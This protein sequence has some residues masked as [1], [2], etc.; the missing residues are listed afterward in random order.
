MAR[1][2]KIKP[3]ETTASNTSMPT[4]QTNGAIQTKSSIYEILGMK[5]T[6]YRQETF[7]EYQTYLDSLNLAEMQRHAVEVANIIPIDD[8]RR[9]VDR[10]EKEYLR[11]NA[12]F[13]PPTQAQII[14]PEE[15]KR[16][17]EKILN[18]RG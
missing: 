10:L 2:K 15:N 17:I 4:H 5:S 16:N 7:A 18:Q 14:I 3:T 8:R 11:L 1:P 13:A 9:L 6:N 12:R